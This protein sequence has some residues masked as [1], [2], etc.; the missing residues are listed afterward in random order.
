MGALRDHIKA[1]TA[2]YWCN[3]MTLNSFNPVH[4]IIDKS[5][6]KI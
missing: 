1:T 4:H 5:W 3:M 2:K 6:F